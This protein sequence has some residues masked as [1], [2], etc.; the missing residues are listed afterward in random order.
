MKIIIGLPLLSSYD[1]ISNDV[2]KQCD[3]LIKN[4]FDTLIY[5]TEVRLEVNRLLLIN[6]NFLI[7]FLKNKENI[8][9]YHHGVAWEEGKWLLNEAECKVWVKYHNVTPSSFYKDYDRAGY[10]ATQAGEIQ[11][12][13]IA[14]HTK[15]DKFI[16][17]SAYNCERLKQLGVESDRMTV[18]PPFMMTEEYNK[19]NID[20]DLATNLDEGNKHFLTVGRVVPNKGHSHLIHTVKSYVNFFG[21][22]I[23]LHVIGSLTM[24]EKRY[25]CELE[26]MINHFNLGEQINFHQN[27]NFDEMHTFYRTVEALIVMSE[28]EG[29][30]LPIAEA[31][32]HKLPI[33]ALDRGAVGETLGANQLSFKEPEYDIFAVA[34]HRIT[35]DQTL[36]EIVTKNGTNNFNQRF[37]SKIILKKLLSLI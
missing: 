10:L 4:G 18:I 14:Q 36:R 16:G 6:R 32:L 27:T 29:F 23:K 33:I 15:I 21:P 25:Y 26:D 17:D 28:H 30:C 34:L 1:A 13:G 7:K 22:R 20:A 8:L 19:A 35:Q 5:A 9:I 11:T 2:L 3:L 12:H 24:E 31:Q 37:Q